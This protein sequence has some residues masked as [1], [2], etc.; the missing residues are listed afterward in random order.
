MAVAATSLRSTTN[1]LRKDRLFLKAERD[2]GSERV[3]SRRLRNIKA[4]DSRVDLA[5]LLDDPW[6]ERRSSRETITEKEQADAAFIDLDKPKQNALLGL[7]STGPSY[8]VVGPPGVGKTK[9]ATETIRRRFQTDRSARLLVSAQGH[10]ALDHLQK[11]IIET[12]DADRM[13]DVIVVRTTMPDRGQLPM[14]KLTWSGWI[15]LTG[16]PAATRSSMRRRAIASASRSEIRRGI[17]EDDEKCRW[18]RRAV[19]A[20]RNLKPGRGRR[21][22]SDFDS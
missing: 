11:K 7:W 6:R 2:T 15:I 18:S 8:L 5:A 17:A 13:D 21:Q 9:L 22:Y 19:R 20:T 16:C 12:L 4:L 10:D 1:F 14:R 3:I